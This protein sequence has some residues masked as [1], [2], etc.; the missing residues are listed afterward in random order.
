MGL[1]VFRVGR[2]GI[3]ISYSLTDFLDCLGYLSI[4]CG[5]MASRWLLTPSIS[6]TLAYTGWPPSFAG[7]EY[8]FPLSLLDSAAFEAT[9]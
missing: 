8:A 3:F 7:F 2:D 5:S 6:L 1:E 4:Q 9:P